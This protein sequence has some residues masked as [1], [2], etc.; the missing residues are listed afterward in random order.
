QIWP[1]PIVTEIAPLTNY[2]PAEIGH[3]E[4]YRLHP[5]QPYCRAVIAPKV[6]KFRK[7]FLDK[8]KKV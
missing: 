5:D 4:Y 7:L 8:L 2:Y 6:A 3:Q 1:D